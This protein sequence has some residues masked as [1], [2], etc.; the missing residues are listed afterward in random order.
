MDEGTLKTP[1]P[2]C[3]FYLGVVQQFFRFCVFIVHS[4]MIL[5][6]ETYAYIPLCN[7]WHQSPQSI[8]KYHY[9]GSFF[10]LLS[11]SYLCVGGSKAA[12]ISWRGC[13]NWSIACR[14][15]R[16]YKQKIMLEKTHQK[17]FVKYKN[18][19]SLGE[20]TVYEQHVWR[21]IQ[22]PTSDHNRSIICLSV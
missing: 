7:N 10:L 14:G 13:A 11:L 22:G 9:L 4:S 12:C 19:Y 3:H 16:A 18:G 1:I 15:E 20:C 21:K 17:Y 8:R 5:G 6:N 2:K